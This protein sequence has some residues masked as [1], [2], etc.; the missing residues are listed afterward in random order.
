MDFQPNLIFLTSLRK[1]M[2]KFRIDV[3]SE[4]TPNIIVKEFKKYEFSSR[5]MSQFFYYVVSVFAIT[6]LY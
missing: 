4:G 2:K 3:I 1:L 5:H 6:F